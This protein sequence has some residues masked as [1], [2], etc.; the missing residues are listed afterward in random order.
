[1]GVS[2]GVDKLKSSD[3]GRQ[4]HNAAALHAAFALAVPEGDRGRER[5]HHDVGRRRI[6]GFRDSRIW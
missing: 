1:M 5:A 3:G 4:L 6:P 2:F